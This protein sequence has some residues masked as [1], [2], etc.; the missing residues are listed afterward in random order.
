MTET[1]LPTRGS[2]PRHFGTDHHE[3][4]LSFP[5]VQRVDLADLVRHLDLDEPIA[6]LSTLGFP[7][8]SLLAASDRG[9]SNGSAQ[10]A[11]ELLGGYRKHRAAAMA[12][13]LVTIAGA[14]AGGSAT[15]P[16]CASRRN[17]SGVLPEPSAAS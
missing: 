10:G 11:D 13:A 12:W 14:A 6:D 16:R 8:L 1:S 3:L 2:S 7:A 4:E 17:G 9:D 15:P 5:A